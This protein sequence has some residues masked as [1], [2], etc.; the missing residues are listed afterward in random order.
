MNKANDC[1]M[2]GSYIC[3]LN[4]ELFLHADNKHRFSAEKQLHFDFDSVHVYY[5]YIDLGMNSLALYK[6]KPFLYIYIYIF[7]T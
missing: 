5:F 1:V 3:G 2:I 7:R 6:W 4:S